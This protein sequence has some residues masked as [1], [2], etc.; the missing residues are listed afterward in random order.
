M[1]RKRVSLSNR[2]KRFFLSERTAL[3]AAAV[4][5]PV[6]PGFSDSLVRIVIETAPVEVFISQRGCRQPENHTSVGTNDGLGVF[7]VAAEILQVPA[8]S[9]GFH[10]RIK[11]HHG[12]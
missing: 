1:K 9:D 8:A 3:V 7:A 2:Y 4:S 11:H 10:Q 6:L 5:L 12:F